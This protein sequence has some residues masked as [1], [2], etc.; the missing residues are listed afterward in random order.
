M[1]AKPMTLETTVKHKSC[2]FFGRLLFAL[3]HFLSF[4]REK[5]WQC[6]LLGEGQIPQ[7]P[8]TREKVA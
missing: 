6:F 3:G 8:P 5:Y 7:A 2:I 4:P 1:V